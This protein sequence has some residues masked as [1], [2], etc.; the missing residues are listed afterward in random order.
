MHFCCK[1]SSSD[2]IKGNVYDGSD[3]SFRRSGSASRTTKETDIAVTVCLEGGPVQIET[4]IGFFDHM[5]GVCR[6][7]RIR[8]D[9]KGQ[10]GFTCR[11]TSHGG[12]YRHRVGGRS[13]TGSGQKN[14]IARLEAFIFP[15]MR[16]LAFAAVDISGRPFLVFDAAF[17]EERIGEYDSCLTREFFRALAFHADITL[18]LRANTERT[19]IILPKPCLKRRLTLWLRQRR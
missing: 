15:W 11:W 14:G 3:R 1:K 4:G 17:P 16:A 8:V 12:G 9:R 18:H 13:V 2:E 10:R 6:P 19:P 5:L 7:R